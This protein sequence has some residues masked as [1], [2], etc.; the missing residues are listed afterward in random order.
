MT[1]K[2]SLKPNERYSEARALYALSLVPERRAARTPLSEDEIATIKALLDHYML[3]PSTKT[4]PSK[5]LLRKT[6]IALSEKNARPLSP[7]WN[8]TQLAVAILHWIEV[9]S[10]LETSDFQPDTH[11]VVSYQKD[12]P[13]VMEHQIKT[14]EDSGELSVMEISSPMSRAAGNRVPI[15]DN[16]PARE[17]GEVAESPHTV[18]AVPLFE[19][20]TESPATFLEQFDKLL[21]E[22][23]LAATPTIFHKHF[24]IIKF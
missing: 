8:K 9:A 11:L 7:K 6:V 4:L 1:E 18:D 2:P 24:L 12:F 21:E 19:G 23:D 14:V 16:S 22:T 15:I 3:S 20:G 5:G 13:T 10:Q 17:E